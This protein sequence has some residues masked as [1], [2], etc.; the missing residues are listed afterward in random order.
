MVSKICTECNVEFKVFNVTGNKTTCKACL[1]KRR[2]EANK[3]CR[4]KR[5]LR[6]EKGEPDF[7]GNLTFKRY[8][9]S[10]KERG[11][12]FKLTEDLFIKNVNAD[13][14]YCGSPVKEVGFD[15]VDNS[16]GYLLENVVVCCTEC[17]RM[18]RTQDYNEFIDRCKR[19]SEKHYN[20]NEL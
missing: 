6:R 16:K 14:Y 13:C 7:I 3:K 4:L 1:K 18:K 10:A 20:I 8:R 5:K 17:N 9:I 12:E 11:L 19:I 15:R 2:A